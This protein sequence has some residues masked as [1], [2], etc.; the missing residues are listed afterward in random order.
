MGTPSHAPF[1]FDPATGK[2]TVRNI[3]YFPKELFDIAEQVTI[4]DM[5]TVQLAPL[6]E[7]LGRLTNL[8]I[9][10]FSNNKKLEE[11]PAVLATCPKLHTVGMR[12]CNIRKIPED[13]LP[14]N[15]RAL[16]L[17]DNH[18]TSL[19]RSIGKLTNLTKLMLAGNHL[20][21]L[22][23][24]LL[25]C[26]NLE[27]A[28]FSVNDLEESPDWLFELP[29]LAWYGDSSNP[30]SLQPDTSRMREIPWEEIT[31]GK[32]IGKSANTTVYQAHVRDGQAVAVKIYGHDL[33]S[34]GLPIDDMNACLRAGEYPNTIGG[35]GRVI[36]TP[37]NAA[38][39]VM[40]LIPSD[41]KNL[42]NPPSL[43]TICRDTYPAGATFT[44]PY[45]CKVL[46]TAADVMRHL[47]S[48]GIMHGDFYA[49]N[50]LTNPAGESYVGDFGAASFY[51]PGT[52]AG[53]LRERIDV[54]AFGILARELLARCH[55]SDKEKAVHAK[56]QHLVIACLD[57]VVARRPSFSENGTTFSHI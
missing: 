47:H 26:Q 16:I 5:S 29:R 25:L 4:L 54:R 44:L 53:A 15:L 49:H 50:I 45:I 56:M 11:I 57:K 27:I 19:P 51:E 28:R 41:F 31:L 34:D 46:A 37:D 35:I 48:Q 42:G 9:A 52:A 33:V 20:Q 23:R 8:Q 12:A 55:P 38:A 7:D 1:D 18:I 24:E 17:T 6:P 3:D 43:S 21:S 22:P 13:S 36:N 14:K 32:E 30:F 39:L 2:V 40:P 10:F